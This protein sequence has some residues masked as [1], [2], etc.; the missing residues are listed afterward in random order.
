MR[1]TNEA[2]ILFGGCSS[3]GFLV[4]WIAFVC[5]WKLTKMRKEKKHATTLPG[6]LPYIY[7]YLLSK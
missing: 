6:K 1:V 2:F 5:Q 4:R 7:I 3:D